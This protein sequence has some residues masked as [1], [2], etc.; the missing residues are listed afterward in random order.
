VVVALGDC[1]TTG[2]V[3]S[4]RNTI[5][6]QRLLQRIYVEGVDVNPGIPKDSVP[7]LAQQARPPHEFVKID[8]HLPGCPPPPKAILS[9]LDDL[10]HNRAVKLT[11]V[12]FG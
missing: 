3:P 11:E 1:A 10:L 2:N 5:P 8:V 6:V 9:V 7:A 4:M 12:R